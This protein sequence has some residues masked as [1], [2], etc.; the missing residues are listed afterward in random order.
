MRKPPSPEDWARTIISFGPPHLRP[1]STEPP[2]SQATQELAVEQQEF[3]I[4]LANTDG[5]RDSASLLVQKKYSWRG[6]M[7]SDV[8]DQAHPNRITL[9]AYH[10]KHIIGT[11]TLGLD[12]PEGLMADEMYGEEIA[13]LRQA[14][15]KVCEL[16]KLAV[17]ENLRSKHILATLFHI[18][19]IYGRIIH[20][21][22]D[23]VIEVNPRHVLFYEK[24]LGFQKWG[25]EKICPRVDAP[26]VLLRLD[27]SYVDEQIAKL[28]G[29]KQTAVRDKSLYPYFFSKEEEAGITHRL[30]EGA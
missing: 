24:M 17:D 16:T 6:Y 2:E 20:G 15:R 14:G 19:Y 27:V 8:V 3:K 11:L 5:R 4:R 10:N 29:L 28:G 9:L 7:I 13:R 1:M 25:E 12:S 18:A 23:V 30:L 26:S 22:T 21:Y